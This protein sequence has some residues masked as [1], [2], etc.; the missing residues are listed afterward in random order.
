MDMIRTGEL[1]GKDLVVM[2]PTKKKIQ[3]DEIEYIRCQNIQWWT[4]NYSITVDP[5]DTSRITKIAYKPKNED[6]MEKVIPIEKSVY[7]KIGGTDDRINETANKI[8]RILTDIEN[9]SRAKYDLR[10][11]HH[12]FAKIMPYWK[13]LT[14][15]EA[16]AINNDV[17]SGEWQIG[18]GYA[19]T[20]D[21]KLN[22]VPLGALEAITGEMLLSAKIISTNTG[23][24][25][26]WLAWPEL[27]SNRAT[28][29]NLLEVVNSSTRRERLIWE[30]KLR[31]LINKSMIMAINAGFEDN[32]ILGE[33]HLE[34]PLIS[35]ANLEDIQETWLPL[36]QLDVISM[37][38]LRSKLPTINPSQE[39][40]MVSKE[41]KVN[42][43]R[44]METGGKMEDDL[45]SDETKNMQEEKEAG[46]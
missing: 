24:P 9:F 2:F 14:Q 18:V 35:L 3:T 7:I 8:H 21:F 37:G 6:S 1:E 44:F 20:A 15:K 43:E 31:E 27:M 36:Q 13:T 10:K 16:N 5:K 39:E 45:R 25:I 33:Y 29:E 34:L 19:G 30:E 38:T 26:H 17:N 4:N 42:M 22:D 32:N 11:N 41:K 23:I 46:K 12:L 28:A 40:K